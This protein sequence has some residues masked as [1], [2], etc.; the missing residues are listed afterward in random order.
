MYSVWNLFKKNMTLPYDIRKRVLLGAAGI[1][2]GILLFQGL[3][4]DVPFM[5]TL[6]LICFLMLPFIFIWQQLAK[7]ILVAILTLTLP[8]NVD[9]TFNLHETH[10]GGAQGYV[11]SISGIAIVLLYLLWFSEL[12]RDRSKRIQWFPAMSVPLL[13]ILLMSVLSLFNAPDRPLGWYE[14]LEFFKMFCIFLYISNYV[15]E[16]KNFHWVLLFLLAGLFLESLIALMQSLSGSTLNLK[17]LGSAESAYMHKMEGE[18]VFRAG[19]TLGGPN[20]LAWYLDFLL[21]LALAFLFYKLRSMS[22]M[23][24]TAAFVMGLAALIL[25][26]SRGG[27]LGF[28]TG[29]FLVGLYQLKR[30]SVKVRMFIVVLMILIAGI[31]MGLLFG[32]DNPVKTRL[33]ADDRGSA[34]VRL[35]LMRVAYRMIRANPLIGNGV[36]NYTLVHHRYDDTPEQVSIQFP[37][38][39]HNFYLQLAAEIGLPGLLFLLIFLGTVFLRLIRLIPGAKALDKPLFIGILAGLC[40]ACIQG[41]VEN[42]TIG[43]YHLLPLWFLAG[44]AAGR[45]EICRSDSVRP[46]APQSGIHETS[47]IQSDGTGEQERRAR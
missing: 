33:T 46:D 39:V 18:R 11:V 23:I 6:A 41:L 5:M 35:P 28:L 10:I 8:L 27:W 40:A 19:G 13:G 25:T 9:Q 14:I 36:N 17:I 34:Y 31:G 24:V 2:T 16:K 38:P 47:E 12:H 43:S 1:I 44:L 45:M 26:L 4:I 29:A 30:L 21:P 20:S 7:Q 3:A 32:T 37:Y 15:R 42:C 22:R